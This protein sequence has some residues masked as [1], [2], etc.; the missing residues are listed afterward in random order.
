MQ[1]RIS[2]KSIHAIEMQFRKLIDVSSKLEAE[3]LNKYC[4]VG[5]AAVKLQKKMH[6]NV[7]TGALRGV[8]ARK[9]RM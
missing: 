4:M 3:M 9:L 7:P 1:T 6:I 2:D 5:V 8:N